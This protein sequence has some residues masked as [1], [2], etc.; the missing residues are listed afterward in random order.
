M[1]RFWRSTIPALVVVLVGLSVLSCADSVTE[2]EERFAQGNE[3]A[4]GGQLDEAIAEYEAVLEA[5]PEN[6]S[7]LTNLGVV[8]YQK[9]D[10]DTA[11]D[12]YVR[13]IGISPEDADIHSNLAAAYMQKY[14]TSMGTEDLERSREEYQT[15]VN[16]NPDLA[17]AHYGLGV[18]YVQTGQVD[19]AIE[20]FETFQ[21]LD[22]GQDPMA[23]EQAEKFLQQL[24]DR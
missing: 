10:L 18:V 16:L 20:S 3:Y 23:S 14:L 17:E 19:K 8:Y 1:K 12:H 7:A 13:A 24:K 11:I 6:V 15:A 9:G 22:S 2:A 4:K 21:A 5:E